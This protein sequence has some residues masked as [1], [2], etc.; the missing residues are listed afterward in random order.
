MKAA[1]GVV[2]IRQARMRALWMKSP[3]EHLN[4][5]LSLN[6]PFVK[7]PNYKWRI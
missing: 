4:K 6:H 1:G 3:T 2:L 7:L 5:T